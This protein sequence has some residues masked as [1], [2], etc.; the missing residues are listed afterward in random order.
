MLN[1]I[2]QLIQDLNQDEFEELK[3]IIRLEI[4]KD[5]IKF[6]LY[7]NDYMDYSED[8][9]MISEI[10]E[11]LVYDSDANISLNDNIELILNDILNS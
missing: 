10:A 6:Y 3:E 7:N 4:A 11:R 2:E 1:N 9:N 8:V 5:D